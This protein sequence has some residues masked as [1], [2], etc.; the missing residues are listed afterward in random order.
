MKVP[1]GK[2]YNLFRQEHRMSFFSVETE[3][4]F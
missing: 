3:L 1:D 4:A 2:L